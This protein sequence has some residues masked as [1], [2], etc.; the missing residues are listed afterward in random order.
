MR[1][2]RVLLTTLYTIKLGVSPRSD[3]DTVVIDVT[4]VND[5]CPVFTH[6]DGPGGSI[7]Y[8]QEG[9][10]IVAGKDITLSDTDADV[11]TSATIQMLSDDNPVGLVIHCRLCGY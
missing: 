9:S 7:R 8:T 1:T 6:A 11:I 5:E 2:N 3:S 4:N 10:V